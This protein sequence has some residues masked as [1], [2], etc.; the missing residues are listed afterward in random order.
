MKSVPL[1][2]SYLVSC[3]LRCSTSR[4]LWCH[5]N[6]ERKFFCLSGIEILSNGRL[7]HYKDMAHCYVSK[8]FCAFWLSSLKTPCSL[9]QIM[10]YSCKKSKQK[11]NVLWQHPLHLPSLANG[12]KWS[13]IQVTSQ[14]NYFAVTTALHLIVWPANTQTQTHNL[15]HMSFNAVYQNIKTV[16]HI[17]NVQQWDHLLLD[18]RDTG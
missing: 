8:G 13:L 9:Y 4:S 15:L 17:I 7:S 1:L 5:C 10:W 6:G 14:W 12:Q 11:L 18:I 2:L 16:K 3:H